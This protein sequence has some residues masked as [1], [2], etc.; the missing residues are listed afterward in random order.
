[1][2]QKLFTLKNIDVS[3]K[4]SSDNLLLLKNLSF[5]IN[6]EET[7][8]LIGKTG[9][10][11]TM[12]GKLLIDLL[13]KNISLK[14]G[15]IFFESNIILS[16]R[17]KLR[18]HIISMIF[19]DPLKSLNPLHTIKKQF[20]LLLKKRFKYKSNRCTNIAQKWLEEVNLPCS[21]NV[22]NRYPHQLSGGQIQRVMIAMA[23]SIKPRLIIADE[24]TTALDANLKFEIINLL[25]TLRIKLKASIVFITH[26]LILAKAYCDR[27]AVLNSG[28]IVEINKTKNIFN[29]PKHPYTKKLLNPLN[30]KVIKKNINN[31][32]KKHLLLN[33]KNIEKSYGPNK[34][35]NKVSLSLYKNTTFGIIG[36]SGS[37]KSTLA[38]I[39]L[40]IL[41]RDSGTIS[42]LNKKLNE[43]FLTKPNKEISIVFQDSL[44]SLN[45]KMTINEVL[46]E[47]LTILKK[48]KKKSKIL[49][50]LDK[51]KLSKNILNRFPHEISGGQRQRISIARSLITNPK[52]LILDEPTSS[53]D[54]NIQEK[55]INLLLHLQK[56][57]KL[58]FLFI[59]HDL[60]II[61]Q[62]SDYIGVM[63]KGEIIESGVATNIFKNPQKKYTK[64]LIQSIYDVS[65][66]M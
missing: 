6:K 62:V 63:Y 47:P 64:K 30:N 32:E 22:L 34:I 55:I 60:N 28:L 26:D 46:Y 57:N 33:I 58:T 24:I 36:E 2:K 44:S 45:P 7:L 49:N 50:I 25:N 56:K 13:P 37:G 51:V 10:G 31:F 52:I 40:N 12:I 29:F 48:N 17:K 14:K 38:K 21:L 23:I 35:L 65:F 11:K 66:K 15:T 43:T 54:A 16:K 27:I 19:Q 39:I 59:S 53:L 41:E 20:I 9:S 1:M 3:L 61:K 18:G 4:N 8:G 5:N 42:L